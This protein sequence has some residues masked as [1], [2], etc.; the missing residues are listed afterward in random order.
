MKSPILKSGALGAQWSAQN[1]C[2][3]MLPSKGVLKVER[4]E[5]RIYI[6]CYPGYEI[7]T[8][9][10]LWLIQYAILGICLGVNGRLAAGAFQGF[11][12]LHPQV[13]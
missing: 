10:I 8:I 12:R 9:A 6:L 7:Q 5:Q 1:S 4:L 13:K 11:A 2:T 3:K